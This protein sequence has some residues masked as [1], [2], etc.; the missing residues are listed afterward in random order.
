MIVDYLIDEMFLLQDALKEW[1]PLLG[2]AW[3]GQSLY[4]HIGEESDKA[5]LEG[6]GGHPTSY[7]IE[8]DHIKQAAPSVLPPGSFFL[9]TCLLRAG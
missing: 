6:L 3:Y 1:M 5:G 9:P 8:K 4:L 2:Q 7:S